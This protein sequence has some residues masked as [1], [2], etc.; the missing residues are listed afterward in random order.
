[1]AH[2]DSFF[3]DGYLH[4]ARVLEKSDPDV[5]GA[6]ADGSMPKLYEPV[7]VRLSFGTITPEMLENTMAQTEKAYTDPN[8]KDEEASE[9]QAQI[10]SEGILSFL[11]DW[12]YDPNE[13]LIGFEHAI[14]YLK[15]HTELKMPEFFAYRPVAY[16]QGQHNAAPYEVLDL[17]FIHISEPTSP[18]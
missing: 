7:F 8:I 16:M 10:T 2:D 1:M 18:Y 15:K 13:L 4:W 9:L 6:R 14:E 11:K 5:N 12:A 3:W 17:S